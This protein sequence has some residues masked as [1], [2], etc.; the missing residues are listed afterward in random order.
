VGNSQAGGSSSFTLSGTRE[1]GEQD[2]AGLTV[3]LPEGLI[4][5]V[6]GI[7]QCPEAQANAG[8]CSPAS[9][10]GE[11]SASAG[12]GAEPFHVTG[13]RAYL[14]GPYKGGPFGLSVVVPTKAGPFNL[15]NEVVRASI[16]INPAT[17]AVTVVSDPLPQQKD[18]V[19][20]RL[21]SVTVN[22]DR[23]GFIVNPTSCAARSIGATLTGSQGAT[24]NVSTPFQSTGCGNLKFHPEFSAS[25]QGNGTTKGNGASLDVKIGYPQPYTAYSN[26]AKADVSLPLALSSKLTTLQKACSE[27][28]FAADPAN[29]PAGSMV[30][31]A[32]AK[33]PLIN[34]PL[35]GP[36]ILVSHA[37]RSFPDLD[38]V[39]QGEGVT[40]V[41]TGNTDIKGGITYSKFETVPDAP[42]SSFE[43]NLPEKE[44]S[45]LAAVKNLCDTKLVMPTEIT[46]QDGAFVKQ[47][48]HI[49]AT[50]CS[51]S[52]SVVSS[53]AKNGTLT[54]SVYAPGAGKVTT[55]A[56]G[57]SSGVKT[58]SGTEAL[59][60]KLKQKKS[61][62]LSTSVKLTF[63]PSKGKKQTKTLKA[64]FKK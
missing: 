21:R 47:S 60:F 8:T 10:V 17:S 18:G 33:S 28:Q 19:M 36:A 26:I 61:G 27:Q 29:C 9:E 40:I 1:D 24:A 54:L 44:N 12:P 6:A 25:T 57:L 5:Q 7:T 55:S 32:T 34:S 46:A 4:G 14:T 13:G 41:L 51:G 53:K 59:T 42:V 49:A 45:I 63:T 64:S 52:L 20:F 31:T 30:G 58:Y 43:L 56:K 3:S 16:R 2:L 50:G 48:T 23:S 62:K 39:L 35:T 38:L 37:N 15:G 22:V 11:V